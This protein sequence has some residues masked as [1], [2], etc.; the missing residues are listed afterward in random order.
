MKQQELLLR[1]FYSYFLQYNAMEY[2][3]G[4]KVLKDMS[5]LANLYAPAITKALEEKNIKV[6]IS[7]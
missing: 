5:P 4:I 3:K 6:I 7:Q 2:L 1:E